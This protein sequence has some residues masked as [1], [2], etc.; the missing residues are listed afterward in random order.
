M[1]DSENHD[2][3]RFDGVE[4]RERKSR[5]NGS[6]DLTMDRDEHLGILLDRPQRRL[7]GGEKLLAELRFL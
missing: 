4:D 7:N 1:Q 2:T 5:N 6:A 3:P